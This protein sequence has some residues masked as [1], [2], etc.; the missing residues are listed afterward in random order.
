MTT[1]VTGV[2]LG[3]VGGFN[4]HDAGVLKAM[5]DC[6]LQ[7]DIITCTSG[8]IYW[9][10]QYL[11]D[12]RG[13]PEKVRQQADQVRG[14]NAVAVAVTGIPGIFTPA[15]LQY[16]KRWLTPWSS[17]SIRELLDRMLPAQVFQPTR[18]KADFTAIAD[19]LNEARV[20]IVF[21]SYSIS[22]GRETLYCNPA[23]FEFLGVSPDTAEH[24]VPGRHSPTRYGP[25]DDGAVTAAL[26]LVLYG[27]DHR[28]QGEVVIDGA[29]HRQLI[30]AEL[31]NCDTVYAVKPQS[32]GWHAAPPANYFEVQDFNTEMW[33]N[34][35]FAAEVAGLQQ[36]SPATRIQPITMNRPLGYFNYF[37]EKTRNYTEA[38]QQAKKLFEH[39]HPSLPAAD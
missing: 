12:P 38:Y 27:M 30:V 5:H 3:G 4:A 29:Y 18:T 11:T 9:V 14:S 28:Y 1:H 8:A 15:Y 36:I 7:P 2:A 26:W 10:Y 22:H 33:F 6:Q 37:V 21:N 24:R 13:I 25:I 39:D 19:A 32:D 35:S 23:A 20:P 31:A 16:V 17:V 34:S